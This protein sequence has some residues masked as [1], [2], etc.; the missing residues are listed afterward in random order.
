MVG[1]GGYFNK[2]VKYEQLDTTARPQVERRL[3]REAC[4]VKPFV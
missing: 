1:E 4:T 3:P 2:N